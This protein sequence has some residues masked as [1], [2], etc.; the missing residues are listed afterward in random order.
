MF[1]GS[2]ETHL[3]KNFSNLGKETDIQIQKR[4]DSS[5]QKEKNNLLYTREPQKTIRFFGRNF[6]GWKRVA[7]YIQN[8]KGEDYQPMIFC[9][10][11]LSIKIEGEIKFS[12][13]VK[14]KG[15]SSTLNWLF[16]EILKILL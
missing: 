14:A 5:K 15:F 7:R 2:T 10:V 9:L 16:Q 3:A 6:V 12:R 4:G 13:Q 11:K 8:A 1:I